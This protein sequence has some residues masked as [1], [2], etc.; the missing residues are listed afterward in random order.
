MRLFER[1]LVNNPVYV[2][3]QRREVANL[4]RL[5]PLPSGL[6]ILDL[7][8]GRG[9]ETALIAS[10]FRPGRL[11]AFDLDPR[12]VHEARRRLLRDGAGDAAL[13][14]ADASRLPF[15]DGRF[16]AVVEIAVIHHVPESRSALPEVAG[17][18]AGAQA[19]RQLP[20]RGHLE[21][22]LRL[23]HE[24]GW[25]RHGGA[26]YGQRV[27]VRG[28]GRRPDPGAAH[29]PAGHPRL[30]HGGGGEEGGVTTTASEVRTKGAA[31]RNAA[32]AL[33][34]LSAAQRN[35]AILNIAGGLL[36][37]QSDI[38]AANGKDMEAGRRAG[39]SEALLDRL[40]L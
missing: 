2:W 36:E 15:A 30:R 18:G 3:L 7:G 39:L 4:R 23:W 17:G 22:T 31:A 29:R 1:L 19:R 16:D 24:A 27:S 5:S 35:Q 40:V 34:R 13:L 33:A 38:L 9:V 14:L 10:V 8:C 37:R 26:V 12:Q 28:R 25:P 21:A 32:R 6:T 11:V 20:L